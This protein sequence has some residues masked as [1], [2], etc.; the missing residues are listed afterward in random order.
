MK[1]SKKKNP[2]PAFHFIICQGAGTQRGCGRLNPFSV[3]THHLGLFF[4]PLSLAA[5]SERMGTLEGEASSELNLD[6]CVISLLI[7]GATRGRPGRPT[8]L[9]RLRHPCGVAFLFPPT[10]TLQKNGSC[11]LLHRCENVTPAT[12]LRQFL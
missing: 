3:I 2:N 7:C 11:L 6:R 4:S 9:G 10:Q 12:L 1:E 5:S 8:G